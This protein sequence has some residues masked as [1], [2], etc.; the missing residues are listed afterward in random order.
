MTQ[1]LNNN[2]INQPIKKKRGGVRA[3]SGR[4]K[5]ST[6]KL[7]AATLLDAIAAIDVP[8][9]QGIAEDY[10]AARMSGDLNVIQKYQN[11]ILSKVIADK[12]AMDVTSN[13]ETMGII[14]NLSPKETGDNYD[15]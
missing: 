14:L 4:K 10:H 12:Q 9:E 1:E 8:F 2:Q 5:G 7:S 3:N 13:G 15:E 6:Q 11:M